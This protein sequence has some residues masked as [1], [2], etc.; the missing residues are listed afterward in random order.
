MKKNFRISILTLI[1]FIICA[2]ST[3]ANEQ[4]KYQ[5]LKVEINDQYIRIDSLIYTLDT[6]GIESSLKI[7]LEPYISNKIKFKTENQ[8][9]N[10]LGKIG[11]ELFL[12]ED[13]P[14]TIYP[15]G[16]SRSLNFGLYRENNF[17]KKK[18]YFKF[19]I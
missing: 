15:I 5:Y 18:V 12:I 9:Y 13:F 11:W 19:E 8:L 17:S 1:V 6:T 16:D 14:N 2:L 10:T 3:S 7:R 4:I